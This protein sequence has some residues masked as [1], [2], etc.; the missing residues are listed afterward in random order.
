M[1]K[2]TKERILDAALAVFAERG[3]A[4]TNLK[5]IADMVG[6]V[7]SALYRHFKSKEELMDAVID[8][9][10]QYYEKHFGSEKNPPS[11]PATLAEFREMAAKMYAFTLHDELIIM[12]RKLL[13]VEQFR[14]EKI[15]A[16]ATK[17][18][19]TGLEAMFTTVFS[20]MT[21]NGIL[22]KTDPA[23]LAFAYTAP[24]SSLIHMSDREPA[25]RQEIEE[26]IKAFTEHFTEIYG[27]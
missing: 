25:R 9:M 16:L 10:S 15:R 14:D 26:K 27:A 5:D 13:T 17:H 19:N 21:E 20:A 23:M 4:G 7:K 24:I 18:F 3:Y 2:D 6:I 22:K 8:R 1:A 12:T 11:V